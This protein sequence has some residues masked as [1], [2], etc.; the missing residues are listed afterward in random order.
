VIIDISN[1]KQGIQDWPRG[2]S[3]LSA[4]TVWTFCW[5]LAVLLLVHPAL[6]AQQTTDDVR[7]LA[8]NPVGDAVK[9]PFVES[10]DFKA[11]LYER[12]PNSF[13]IQPV[14][15]LPIGENW[16]LIP[17]I[18]ATPVAYVPN[19]TQVRG[20]STGLGDTVASL[21]ITPAHAGKLVWGVGPSVL[22]PTATDVNIGTGRWGL[23][24]S[25]AVLTEPNWGSAGV[26]VQNIWSL[27]GDS[28]RTSVNQ[29][30]IETSV[31]Y[32]LPRGWY[33]VTAPTM[34]ADWTQATGE[35]WVVPFG[36][37]AGRTFTVANQA[38]DSNITLYYNAIRPASGLSPK[39]QISLQLTLLY[40]K[41]R[42]STPTDRVK[43]RS[44]ATDDGGA[45]SFENTGQTQR[46]L[47]GAELV[48]TP[49][50]RREF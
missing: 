5:L 38:V 44:S 41:K 26:V 46:S 18:V 1:G 9:V 43:G 30:Q 49:G 25:V 28:H 27:P 31:S 20:G 3:Q 12:M 32:N 22:I 36:G 47:T 14:I 2:S 11:G 29:I 4:L 33:L 45:L 48:T 15:P 17:R 42:K 8:R 23:G 40:P 21:F 6:R 24:P 7:N 19:V 35:R 10:I 16:L 39:W 34:N 13:Q 37:G 50:R